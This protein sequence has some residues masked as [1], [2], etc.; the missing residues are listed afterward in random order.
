MNTT[1]KFNARRLIITAVLALIA[2]TA[3]LVWAQGIV[4]ELIVLP[5]SYLLYAIRVLTITT[6]EWYFWVV[7]LVIVA[8]MASRSLTGKKKIY[9]QPQLSETAELRHSSPST[10]RTL[11]WAQKVQLMRKGASRF[12]TTNFHANYAR[13]L[14]AVLSHRYRI[15][16]REVEERL[17][18]GDMDVPEP[19][20]EYALFALRRD[21]L[22][23]TAFLPW[24]WQNMLERLRGLFSLRRPDIT[25]SAGDD[26]RVAAIL[27]YIEDELEVSHDNTGR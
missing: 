8:V 24:L 4:R 11:Y 5:L 10:G 21:E 23:P 3:I 7:M 14:V 16:P 12:Y 25:S 9:L 1:P 19:V 26:P 18:H 13:L 17:H 6:P 27:Q 22:Q 20:R 2:V 15:T